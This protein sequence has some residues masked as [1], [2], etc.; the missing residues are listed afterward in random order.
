MTDSSPL[1]QRP[2]T[3]LAAGFGAGG[4]DPVEVL[5]AVLA[6]RES[7]DPTLNAVVTL[8]ADGARRAAEASAAR[9][10]SGAPLSPID[11]VPVTVKDNI[12]VA[13]MRSTWGSLLYADHVPERDEL[14]VA[15]LRAAGAVIVGKTNVP[16]FTL[17][18]YTDNRLFGLTRNPWNT[19]LTPGGSSGGAVAAVAA[20]IGPV[21]IGTD[22]GGSIRRPAAHT[23]LV[24]LK[25]STGRVARIDG[26]PAVLHDFEVIGPIARSVDDL[27]AFMRVICDAD[28]RD[29]LSA[30]FAGRPFGLPA[31]V[32]PARIR[33]VPRF[34]DSPVDPEIA[35]SVARAA[36][37]L[38]A[39]GHRLDEDAR[40]D[41]ADG[42]NRTA[43]SVISQT[44]LAWLMAQHPG[45]EAALSEPLQAMLA[46]ARALSAAQYLDALGE[47][48]RLRRRFAEL[49]ETVDVVMTPTTAALAWSSSEVFPSVI[50]GRPA[51][52]RAHAVFTAFVNAAGLPAI[53][54][55]ADPSAEG[56]PLG[57]QLI[58]RPGA[59][60]MLCA[61]AR[62]F[63][64]AHP[65][66]GRWPAI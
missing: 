53:T 22:G 15:R 59:D 33:F 6:R 4:P 66:A 56:L 23:S 64:A 13:G 2:A 62:Q 1:W 10:R 27:V 51:G 52:P 26:F 11:G 54:I 36:Q 5:D 65:W 12:P 49:F 47:V 9:W 57:F 29:P 48:A 42:V 8:D 7:V 38:A 46:D 19:G 37:R 14:P 61:L 35:A 44:A 20:G 17:Q 25:P 30:P 16:E 45:Q 55:P 60:G 24:G 50:D 41:L 43:W 58:G 34:G 18:G 63:E 39:L 28:P 3:R 31:E 40:F 21:A 32:A